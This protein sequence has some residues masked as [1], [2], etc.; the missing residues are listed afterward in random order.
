MVGETI[1]IT[2][3]KDIKVFSLMTKFMV[4]DSTSSSLARPMKVTGVVG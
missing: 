4:M 3:V 1:I 2:Q